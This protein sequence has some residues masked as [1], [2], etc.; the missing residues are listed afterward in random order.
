MPTLTKI[1][2]SQ[3]ENRFDSE[4]YRPEYLDVE[5]AIEDYPTKKSIGELAEIIV[6]GT[7]I[8]EYVPK[9]VPYLRV[10]DAREIFLDLSDV[11]YIRE[12]VE[13]KKDIELDLNDLLFSRSGTIGVVGIVTEDIKGGIISSHLIRVKLK[14]INPYFA[15]V[16]FNSKYGR[17]Q[18]L[19]RNN[20]TVV[21]EINQPALKSIVV[22]IPPPSFQE[23]IEELVKEAHEKKKLAEQRYKEAEQLLYKELGIEKLE[24]TREK[25]FETTFSEVEK[26]MRFDSEY[27]QPKYGR[28]IENARNSKFK[29]VKLGTL[30]EGIKYGTSEKVDYSESGIPF[31][32]VTDINSFNTMDIE[33]I[34]RIPEYELPRVKNAIIRENEVLIS[35]TG[36]I[37][38]AVYINE[39]LKNS[40]FGSYF[41]KIKVDKSKI[42]PLY[43][44]MFLNSQL[45]KLQTQRETS[46]AI[47]TNITIPIIKSL[48]IIVPDT[49]IQDKICDVYKDALQIRDASRRL[50]V[51]AKTDVEELIEKGR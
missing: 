48:T 4:Y 2:Y 10:S 40:I 27:Y 33:D 5:N 44:S 32:R 13:V 41:I 19:R 29:N 51:Q 15:V 36:T 16:F 3:L 49:E 34:K 20:G 35:R 30:I 18:I 17:L 43:L 22:P 38:C 24:L 12:N 31:L 9:G 6:N 28:N 47:Q 1:K 50:I 14:S 46:G 23:H 39:K 8:R 45:G 21:P 7:E 42:N 25:N 26:T 11:K 37:G